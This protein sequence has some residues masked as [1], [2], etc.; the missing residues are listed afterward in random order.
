[1]SVAHSRGLSYGP[2]NSKIPSGSDLPATTG[3]SRKTFRANTYWNISWILGFKE[4]PSLVLLIV[5]GGALIG[6]CL[7]RTMM[8]DPNNVQNLTIPGEWFW[9]RQTPFKPCILIHIYS[10]IPGGILVVLQ[11][12]P[13]IRRRA[14]IV[15]RING[16]VS[17]TLISAGTVGGSIVARRAFGGELNAQSGFYI[18]SS[19]IILCAGLGIYN[20]K[21][22]R[23][24]RK[25]MLRTVSFVG[26]PIT[27][28]LIMLCARQVISDIGTYYSVWRCDEVQSVVTDERTLNA[29]YPQ[30]VQTNANPGKVQVAVHAATGSNPLSFA[31]SVRATFGM[32]LWLAMMIHLICVEFYI[33][34]TE[35]ENQHRRGF[36]LER[37]DD[38]LDIQELDD[39]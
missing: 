37:T 1:M 24:H 25:W 34:K 30:C 32:G 8:M 13:A 6:F 19:L 22:T 12:I 7:G 18:L 3:P 35:H 4:R 26:V 27:T 5:F 39:H 10:L 16:Y 20:R 29:T 38:E 28:R 36:V 17:L 9:Y 2:Y 15:H 23:K 11:F 31:S 21:E 14:V 33:R